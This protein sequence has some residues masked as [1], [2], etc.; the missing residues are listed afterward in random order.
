MRK[1]ISNL[2]P[3]RSIHME[4]EDPTKPVKWRSLRSRGAK[5]YAWATAARLSA[6]GRGAGVNL[7]FDPSSPVQSMK[8]M[9]KEASET[10]L[11]LMRIKATRKQQLGEKA[12]RERALA[13]EATT[14]MLDYL[15][16]GGGEAQ[17][18]SRLSID[19]LREIG[20]SDE[21]SSQDRRR[22]RHHRRG[23]SAGS[24]ISDADSYGESY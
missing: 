19:A 23:S 16:A 22:S 1:M 8:K 18:G 11:E 13:L 2:G 14:R 3:P 12:K 7:G 20:A 21:V 10:S 17:M 6:E 24:T 4:D 15:A 5:L 9:E